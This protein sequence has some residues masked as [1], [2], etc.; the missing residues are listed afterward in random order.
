MA[1]GSKLLP[2]F[3]QD[4]VWED[5]VKNSDAPATMD[6]F[7]DR[8]QEAFELDDEQMDR[9]EEEHI[10]DMVTGIIDCAGVAYSMRGV[11][12]AVD[13]PGKKKLVT[14]GHLY[15]AVV[16]ATVSTAFFA[17]TPTAFRLLVHRLA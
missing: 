12:I 8:G 17:S 15:L 1:D 16:R 7:D 11:P 9:Q 14:F 4:A 3:L 13:T 2:V 10:E 6:Y 5:Y